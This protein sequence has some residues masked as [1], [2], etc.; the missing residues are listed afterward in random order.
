MEEKKKQTV[1]KAKEPE[2][3][4]GQVLAELKINGLLYRVFIKKYI[5]VKMT[6][7]KWMK[8]LKTDKLIK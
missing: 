5:G 3:N 1:K 8:Q 7:S 2:I 4:I 6:H